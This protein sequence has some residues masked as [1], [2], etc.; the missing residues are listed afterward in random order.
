MSKLDQ[1]FKDY[2]NV[3]GWSAV[4]STDPTRTRNEAWL[5]QQIKDLM[6]EL[7]GEN[8]EIKNP[9][10]HHSIREVIEDEN[11]VKAEIRKKVEEL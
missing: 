4:E 3:A 2:K 6:L 8:E 7:I 1:I 9:N 11:T 5:K 10:L